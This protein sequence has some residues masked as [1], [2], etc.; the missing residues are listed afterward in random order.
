MTTHLTL[1]EL[2]QIKS[3]LNLIGQKTHLF[4]YCERRTYSMYVTAYQNDQSSL[5]ARNQMTTWTNVLSRIHFNG[6]AISMS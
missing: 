2:Y 6:T 1:P 4:L 5:K 3:P